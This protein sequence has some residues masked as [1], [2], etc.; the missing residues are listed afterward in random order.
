MEWWNTTLVT[1]RKLRKQVK[2]TRAYP[3]GMHL[4]N[5][6]VA[7]SFAHAG[8]NNVYFKKDLM[9]NDHV[10]ATIVEGHIQW[11]CQWSLSSIAVIAR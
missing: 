11:T 9:Q 6:N 10:F 3:W 7:Q 5:L 2:K 8:H 1:N 4:L